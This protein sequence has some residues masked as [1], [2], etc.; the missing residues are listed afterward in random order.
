MGNRFTSSVKEE[1]VQSNYRWSKPLNGSSSELYYYLVSSGFFEFS[2]V[3]LSFI[4]LFLLTFVDSLGRMQVDWSKL[5]SGVR[6]VFLDL[7]VKYHK[8]FEAQAASNI[9]YRFIF[10]LSLSFLPSLIL[11]L[12]LASSCFLLL[13]LASSC[14]V[15]RASYFCFT[16]VF[17]SCWLFVC[18]SRSLGLCH[19]AFPLLPRSVRNALIDMSCRPHSFENQADIAYYFYGFALMSSTWDDMELSLCQGLTTKL[20]AFYKSL[21]TK[22]LSMIMYSITMMSFGS[23]FYEEEKT[24]ETDQLP[25]LSSSASSSASFTQVNQEQ[26]IVAAKK[27]EWFTR[28]DF[29]TKIH[30]YCIDRFYSSSELHYPQRLY[31]FTFFEQ[32]NILFYFELMKTFTPSIRKIM[33]QGRRIPNITPLKINNDPKFDDIDYLNEITEEPNSPERIELENPAG[34]EMNTVKEGDMT[35]D[36]DDVGD[37]VGLSHRDRIALYIRQTIQAM[38]QEETNEIK[39][40]KLQDLSVVSLFFGT[41]SQLLPVDITIQQLHEPKI[42]IEIDQPAQYII[43]FKAN[44]KSY[45][46]RINFFKE[47]LYSKTY[48]GIPLYRLK[49]KEIQGKTNKETKERINTL[50]RRLINYTFL[51]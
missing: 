8:E 32:R 42:F 1:I 35:N 43:D 48:P 3:L 38:I 21:S 33:M 15:I 27:R 12:P 37:T 50:I 20:K 49:I 41:E 36:E 14:F 44:E 30:D 29:L 34:G 7:I 28:K 16:L 24:S 25:T 2:L 10:V 26:R 11:L 45:L 23:Q 31:D 51:S 46:K 40:M 9:I 18:V 22:S 17:V 4:L 5:S 13:P 19:A 47:Y 39:K 6:R